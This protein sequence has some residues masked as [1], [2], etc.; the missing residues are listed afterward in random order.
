MSGKYLEIYTGCFM[1]WI[2]L[3]ASWTILTSIFYQFSVPWAIWAAL[4]LTISLQ[5]ARIPP[6]SSEVVRE[7]LG[8]D[9]LTEAKDE[10][11][12]DSHGTSDHLYCMRVV[13]HRGAAFDYPENSLNAFRNCKN[14]G[15]SAVEFDLAL[16]K[17]GVPII[18]H[19][20]TIERL[21]GKS[22]TVK[23]MTWNQ[24]KELDISRNH[25]LREKFIGEDKIALLEDVL[26]E[27]IRNDLR[28][29][30]D[31][32]EKSLEIVQVILDAYNKHPS[33]F[34]RAVV[35]SFNPIIIY[36][37]RRKNPKIVCSIA[38]RPQ[39][40]SRKSYQGLEG[41]GLPRFSNPFKHALAAIL[42]CLHG[43]A[44]SRFTYHL[45]GLSAILLHKD[46]VTPEV[47]R[48]W[49]VRG[50]RVIVW[51]VNLPSEKL[52]YSRLLKVTYL[53]D[54]LIGEKSA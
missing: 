38:W 24:L 54:T 42:D 34:K 36:L 6:P 39:L 13:G 25:P 44:L 53:T 17:D 14:R 29:F 12:G 35:T 32:K 11:G 20:L 16:T 47:V 46:I 5:V 50:V 2:Y 51:N 19:D 31:I 30:I 48:K 37:I 22:G 27:C 21:T 40:I 7:V 41:P 33:L 18:F 3:Q 9:P 52:H 45:L 49:N 10:Q 15:C 23:E 8:V 43:W 4:V 26:T 28:M 1:A